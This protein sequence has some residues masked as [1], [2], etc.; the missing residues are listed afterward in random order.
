[1]FPAL[2]HYAISLFKIFASGSGSV[3]NLIWNSFAFTGPALWHVTKGLLLISKSITG[4]V[5]ALAWTVL[6]ALIHK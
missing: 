1:M 4:S 2:I 6:T 5:L 3:I